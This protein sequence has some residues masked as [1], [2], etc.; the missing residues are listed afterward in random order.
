MKGQRELML[1]GLRSLCFKKKIFICV[2]VHTHDYVCTDMTMCAH[3]RHV[4]SEDYLQE[5][6][7]S[8]LPCRF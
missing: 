6:V 4:W 3:M 7:L 8:F 1:H 2:H 5:S